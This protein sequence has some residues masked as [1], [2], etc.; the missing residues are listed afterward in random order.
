MR[1]T[2]LADRVLNQIKNAEFKWN[3]YE[4][5]TS[6]PFT[7]PPESNEC[8]TSFC[9][10]GRA[11]LLAGRDVL[12]RP[13]LR[14][15][16]Y[17]NGCNDPRYRGW[18]SHTKCFEERG[19]YCVSGDFKALPDDEPDSVVHPDGR[20]THYYRRLSEV[21]EETTVASIHK[22]YYHVVDGNFVRY[23]GPV[24]RADSAAIASLGISSEEAHTLFAASNTLG[25]LIHAVDE[26]FH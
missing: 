20:I 21:Y 8:G 18:S 7:S 14:L 11:A 17:R 22:R 1:N 2:E 5:A 19:S 9:F 15:S 6:D 3:Q 13:E 24:I 12:Y 4:W 23:Y 26:I 10:A 25:Y 16:H